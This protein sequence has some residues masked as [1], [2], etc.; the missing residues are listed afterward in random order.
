MAQRNPGRIIVGALAE[1]GR[2][3]YAR[4]ELAKSCPQIPLLGAMCDLSSVIFNYRINE[5]HVALPIE[6]FLTS[7]P[8]LHKSAQEFG[9]PVTLV[10]GGSKPE[11]GRNQS[12]SEKWTISLNSHAASQP[13]WRTLKRIC[14][15]V[16]SVFAIVLLLPLLVAV[17]VAIKCTSRGPVLFRQARVGIGRSV[18]KMYKF[19]TMVVNAEQLRREIQSMN[20]AQGI[21][22]KIINDPRLT[23]IG[24][25]LRR[26]SIDELPQLLNVLLG[27]M[28]MVGP[29]PI[30]VWV[31]EQLQ[32]TRWFRR[33]S[34]LPG[35][36]G[37]WQVEGRQQDF[38][39]MASKDLKY[40]DEWS[41]KLDFRILAKTIPAVLKGSNAH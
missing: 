29:R 6:S 10:V 20:D 40:V 13:P 12:G 9:I 8:E 4:S 21:S 36:S 15:I 31:A 32:D 28:S 22:F 24:S 18:F 7:A 39:F 14:D 26:T 37:L 27:D 33:F 1:T 2:T 38:D 23:R 30:P 41:M 16:L 3:E 25:V 35:M 19:R 11:I 34:V 5:I 17:A